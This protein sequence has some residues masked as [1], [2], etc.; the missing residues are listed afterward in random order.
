[1]RHIQQPIGSNLC[2]QT[3]IAMILDTTIEAV[4]HEM[5]KRGKTRTK[6]LVR[7]LRRHGYDVPDRL[8]R[9]RQ[10][11]LPRYAIVKAVCPTRKSQSHWMVIWNHWLYDPE[12]DGQTTQWR[13][14][15]ESCCVCVCDW[16]IT[17]FLPLKS[18][19]CLVAP[20]A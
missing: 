14:S 8:I 11:N 5:G 2:G 9:Q 1:M 4:C 6:D 13:T 3:C 19:R 20:V 17:S 12:A 10:N 7:V 15:T 18:Y 16:P